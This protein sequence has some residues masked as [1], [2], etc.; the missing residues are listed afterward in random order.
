MRTMACVERNFRNVFTSLECVERRNVVREAWKMSLN[1]CNALD[2]NNIC[3]IFF[4]KN[5]PARKDVFT[6]GPWKFQAT[7][8]VRLYLL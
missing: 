4:Y 2:R 7:P 8:K 1:P 5:D 3:L 6:W